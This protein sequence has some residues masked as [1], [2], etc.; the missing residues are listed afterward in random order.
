MRVLK[1]ACVGRLNSVLCLCR[2]YS[3][4]PAYRALTALRK[5]Y[6]AAPILLTT[7]SISPSD[8]ATTVDIMRL[9]SPVTI[10]ADLN[11]ANLQFDV[12][13]KDANWQRQVLLR[14]GQLVVTLGKGIVWTRTQAQAVELAEAARGVGVKCGYFHADTPDLDKFDI[15]KLF[16]S[17]EWSVIFATSAFGMGMDISDLR[18]SLHSSIPQSVEA[19][20]QEAG[21]VG[22]DGNKALCI[23]LYAWSDVESRHAMLSAPADESVTLHIKALQ[24]EFA[25]PS[26]TVNVTAER[27][28]NKLATIIESL[29]VCLRKSLL[30]EIGQSITREQC[31]NTC[32]Y[33]GRVGS[34]T[35]FDCTEVVKNAIAGVFSLLLSSPRINITISLLAKVLRGLAVNEQCQA[36]NVYNSCK[37]INTATVTRVLRLMIGKELL[38]GRVNTSIPRHPFVLALGPEA[39]NAFESNYSLIINVLD[40]SRKEKKSSEVKVPFALPERVGVPHNDCVL[41]TLL[42]DLQQLAR[43]LSV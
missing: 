27:A 29:G 24:R 32:G 43:K 42:L 20:W 38:Q 9:N 7:G 19:W 37:N 15:V 26:V 21:R 35:A 6:P 39:V 2:G 25:L 34:Y 31:Q 14:V 23:L 22:R 28:L 36:V 30:S 10:R 18:W 4:R 41:R 1:L 16:K 5:L 33:C 13:L 8:L 3:F 17:G 40:S 11:R 12:E